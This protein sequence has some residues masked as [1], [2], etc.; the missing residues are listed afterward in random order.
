VGDGMSSGSAVM[1][2]V[3]VVMLGLRKFYLRF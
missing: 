3:R 1:W 2:K